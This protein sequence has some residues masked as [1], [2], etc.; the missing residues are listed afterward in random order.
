LRYVVVLFLAVLIFGSLQSAVLAKGKVSKETIVSG[1]KKRIYYLYTPEKLSADKPLPLI[2]MLHGSNRNGLSLVEKWVDIAEKEELLLV[3][4]DSNNS[5]QWS[6]NS[7]GPSFLFD[8][9]EAQKAKY[10]VDG[11]RVYIFGHSA[12]A[13]FGL[14][15][16]LIESQYF[17][18]VAVHAGALRSEDY[19]LFDYAKRKIP[20]A[21]F[22]GDRD[23]LFPLTIVK[24]T[25]DAFATHQFPVELT[26]IE[27]H[28]HWYYEKASKI[29]SEAWTFLKSHSLPQEP[30][31]ELYEVK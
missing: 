26:A 4:P 7:D 2:V 11:K 1:T 9:V 20:V 6:F 18:A 21:L 24:A 12:G 15:M 16:G 22:V 27:N 5:A 8:L 29:N 30:H 3:G 28:D 19:A 25:R 14:M 31:Y 17:A 13:I 10:P 23:P